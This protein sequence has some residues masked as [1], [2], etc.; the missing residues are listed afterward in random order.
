MPKSVFWNCVKG[1]QCSVIKNIN[2]YSAEYGPYG[3]QNLVLLHGNTKDRLS[4]N[5]VHKGDNLQS[6]LLLFS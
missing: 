2:V 1:Q 5:E 3:E 6:R 4:Q